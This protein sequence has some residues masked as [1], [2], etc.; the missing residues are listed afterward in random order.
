MKNL[1]VPMIILAALHLVFSGLTAM[2]GASPT[3]VR[4][5]SESS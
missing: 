1:R 2:G 3:A 4:S 5:P